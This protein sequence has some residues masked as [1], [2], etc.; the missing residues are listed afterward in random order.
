MSVCLFFCAFFHRC[1]W[2]THCHDLPSIDLYV[3]VLALFDCRPNLNQIWTRRGSG[4]CSVIPKY[5]LLVYC[6]C[7]MFCSTAPGFVSCL[8]LPLVEYQ[9]ASYWLKFQLPQKLEVILVQP[10]IPHCD[11]HTKAWYSYLL[12]HDH[13]AIDIVTA[14]TS[15]CDWKNELMERRL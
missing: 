14:F 3:Y 9:T 8:Q 10:L 2:K 12:F 7:Y 4:T 6:K 13:R 11:L 5:P 1:R 15:L